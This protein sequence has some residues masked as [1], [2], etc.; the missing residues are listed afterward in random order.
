M[1]AH[2][3]EQKGQQGAATDAH[4]SDLGQAHGHGYVRSDTVGQ[5]GEEEEEEELKHTFKSDTRKWPGVFWKF[6]PFPNMIV[7]FRK[8]YHD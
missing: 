7:I 5:E 8:H 4:T 6:F 1:A 3:E 2:K